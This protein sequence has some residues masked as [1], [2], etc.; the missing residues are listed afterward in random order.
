MENVAREQGLVL[1]Q[2]FPYKSSYSFKNKFSFFSDGG[3]I[4]GHFDIFDMLFFIW[5]LSSYSPYFCE[6][7]S[8]NGLTPKGLCPTA[9]LS[10]KPVHF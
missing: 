4:L 5:H 2:L 1:Q 7:R 9:Q 10:F 3:H 6:K 8:R